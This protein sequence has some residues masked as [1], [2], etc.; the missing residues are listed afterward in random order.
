MAINALRRVPNAAE[1]S[2]SIGDP[3]GAIFLCVG[4]ARPVASGSRRCPGCGARFVLDVPVR[5]ASALAAAGLAAGLVVGGGSVGLA[6]VASAPA[7]PAAVTPSAAPASV[8]TAAPIPRAP[9]GGS[10][11]SIAG[12]PPAAVAALRGTTSINARMAELVAPLSAELAADTVDASN[13][14]RALR[15]VALEVGA[16][17]TLVPALGTWADADVYAGELETFY[18]TLADRVREGLSASLRNEAAYRS[19][20]TDVLALLTQLAAFEA[21]ARSLAAAADIPASSATP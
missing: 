18:V 5:R 1:G 8:P 19:A 3:D 20:A 10:G 7:Q 6:A 12:I 2:I 21:S 9:A 4:C 13:V 17:E 16:A 11:S 15:R 14:A